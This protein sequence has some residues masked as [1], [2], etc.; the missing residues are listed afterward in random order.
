MSRC[1]TRAD[2]VKDTF[3]WKVFGE[4]MDAQ[5]A[6]GEPL[7]SPPVELDSGYSYKIE[8][9]FA[10]SPKEKREHMSFYVYIDGADNILAGY[11][12]CC[13]HFFAF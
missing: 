7:C 8:L 6:K 3:K 2:I 12:R 10:D 11:V 9:S 4:A 13:N 5:C 1:E